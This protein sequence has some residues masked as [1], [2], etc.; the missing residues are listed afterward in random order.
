MPADSGASP[1]AAN[2][3]AQD[4][5]DPMQAMDKVAAERR[6]ALVAKYLE[7]AQSLRSK[8]ELEAAKRLLVKAREF[9][10][11]NPQVISQLSAIQA[12]LG[13]PTGV[14]SSYADEQLQLRQIGEE[15][16]RLSVVAQSKKAQALA[17]EKDYAGAL[18]ELRLAALTIELKDQ[19]D[20]ADLPQRISNEKANIERLYDEQQRASQA[21]SNQ[22]L[23]ERLRAE[24]AAAE[25]RRRAQVNNHLLQA[26]TAFERKNFEYAQLQ[27][28]KAMRWTRTA[29][30]RWRCT[31]R[32]SRLR[33]RT[34]PTPTTAS[35]PARSAPCSKRTS[36]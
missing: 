30:S 14:I 11:T 10:P 29:R 23:A 19:V 22:Q 26:Q 18:E 2:P 9:A 33:A 8:G 25:A 31:A 21:A 34:P 35:G 15:R 3:P 7:D 16:A 1:T 28:E 13:E 36:S 20:W 5:Q 6:A 4:P 17:D 12:E 24:H 27:A 32:R